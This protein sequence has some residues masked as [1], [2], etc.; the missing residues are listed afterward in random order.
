MPPWWSWVLLFG[1]RV[2]LAGLFSTHFARFSLSLGDLLCFDLCFS[3]ISAGFPRAEPIRLLL[4]RAVSTRL[5]RNA[6]CTE[7][8]ISPHLLILTTDGDV[9]GTHQYEVLFGPLGLH[10]RVWSELGRSLPFRPMRALR[11]Q[12]SRAFSLV[13]EVALGSKLGMTFSYSGH[14]KGSNRG[15][16]S[17]TSVVPRCSRA[18]KRASDWPRQN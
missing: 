15:P 17:P 14:T 6:L 18:I 7:T 11:L 5:V 9:I 16:A 12:C 3:R 10:L 4:I 13:C 2:P 8:G 1:S